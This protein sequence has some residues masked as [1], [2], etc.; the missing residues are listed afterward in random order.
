MK[1]N[2]MLKTAAVATMLAFTSNAI[3]QES[4][5]KEELKA[6]KQMM[7]KAPDIGKVY[8][9][10]G[11]D[12][13]ILSTAFMSM[14]GGDTKLTTPRFTTFFHIGT[15]FHYNF[16]TSF[17]IFTGVGIKNIGFIEKFDS[18]DSTVK[19]RVYTIGIPVGIKIGNM[20]EGSY[21]MLG[22]GIDMPFNFKEKGFIKRNDKVKFNEWFSSRTPAIMPYVFLG[23]RLRPGFIFKLQYYPGNFL[24]PDF[25]AADG[26]TPY[27]G[28]DVQLTTLSF[29]FNIPY[30]PKW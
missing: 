3:A 27:A 9:T 20:T 10:S 26:S 11:M 1:N 24:N 22:G 12:G 30:R 17:G 14:N 19:R 7:M 4:E 21:F 18:P 29:G 25:K 16:S 6:T 2:Y 13:N 15:N 28:Y 5:A 23:T 8:L